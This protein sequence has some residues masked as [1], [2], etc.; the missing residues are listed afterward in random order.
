MRGRASAA[1]RGS[2]PRP[3]EP[4]RADGIPGLAG[5]PGGVPCVPD[6]AT[7]ECVRP[8]HHRADIN[9]GGPDEMVAFQTERDFNFSQRPRHRSRCR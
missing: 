7:G 1:A 9:A 3:A 4:W 5:H 8:Y 2:C 6:P